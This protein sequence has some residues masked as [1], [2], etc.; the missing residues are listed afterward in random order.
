MRGSKLKY[1]RLIRITAWG[2]FMIYM[3]GMIYFLFGSDMLNRNLPSS[4]YRYNLRPFKEIKRCFYCLKH[5][6]TRYFILNFCMNIVAFVP[7]GTV[8]PIIQE[9]SRK[10]YRLLF[11]SVVVIFCIEILQL[12]SKVGIF[13]V[14]DML[15]NVSGSMIGYTIFAVFRGIW[16]RFWNYRNKKAGKIEKSK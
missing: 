16:K 8:L 11:Q 6:N 12:I 3:A 4:A 1:K 5:N 14:D 15:L 9:K 10:W 2:L 13:D 7:F